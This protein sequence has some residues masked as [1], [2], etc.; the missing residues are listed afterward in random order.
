MKFYG[1]RFSNTGIVKYQ[2]PNG[3]SQYISNF[4]IKPADAYTN[5]QVLTRFVTNNPK[6][7]GVPYLGISLSLP[8]SLDDFAYPER[9]G[10]GIKQ[11]DKSIRYSESLLIEPR[12]YGDTFDCALEFSL[13]KKKRRYSR[14]LVSKFLKMAPSTRFLLSL[15]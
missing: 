15:V 11:A 6:T 10:R 5:G 13:L 9:Y 8:R 1:R 2:K 7:D 14:M 3:T 4:G 12:L